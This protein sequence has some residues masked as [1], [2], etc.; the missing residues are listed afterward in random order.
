MRK[1]TTSLMC[2]LPTHGH[3]FRTDICRS[4]KFIRKFR[5]YIMVE[6]FKPTIKPQIHILINESVIIM[7]VCFDS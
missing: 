7:M 5:N 6:I 1:D 3:M 2:T 4:M